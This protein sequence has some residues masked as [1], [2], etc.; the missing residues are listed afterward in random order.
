M[1]IPVGLYFSCATTSSLTCHRSLAE[2]SPS[3][4]AHRFAGHGRTV[5]RPFCEKN[6]DKDGG[7]KDLKEVRRRGN[8]RGAFLQWPQCPIS[9]E[10]VV[11]SM[12]MESP[13]G[14]SAVM[15]GSRLISVLIGV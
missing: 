10:T 8:V 7:T 2:R 5:E 1:R 11:D 3:A 6:S 12:D 4:P 13:V 9:R 15:G 14:W